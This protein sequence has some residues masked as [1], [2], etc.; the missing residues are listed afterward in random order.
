MPV[1]PVLSA[2]IPLVV[3]AWEMTAPEQPWPDPE[4]GDPD[5]PYVEPTPS[6]TGRRVQVVVHRAV[7]HEVVGELVTAE[8]ESWTED[9][10]LMVSP[11][12]AVTVS[13][14]DPLFA[15]MASRSWTGV[16]GEVVRS[17]NPKDY[18]C[19]IYLAGRPVSSWVFRRPVSTDL[20]R[21]A[22]ALEGPVAVINERFLGRIEQLDRLSGWGD[23]EN[24]PLGQE[25][26]GIRKSGP[27]VEAIVV[28]GGV[29]GTK[30]LRITGIG[31]IDTPMVAL[32][33]AEGHSR[34]TEGSLMGRWPGDIP[35]GWMVAE[36][37]TQRAD[38]T[39][40]AFPAFSR[41]N[42]GRRP[43]PL[44]DWSDQPVT[45]LATMTE[46]TIIHHTWQRIYS[47]TNPTFV[48]LVTLRQPALTG[49]LDERDLSEYP[50]RLLRTLNRTGSGGSPSGITSSIRSLTGTKA[51]MT[52]S[53]NQHP[54]A[55]EAFRAVL[56]AEGGPECRI[57]PSWVLEVWGR[58]GKSRSDLSITT[59]DVLSVTWSV[60]PG[61]QV[62]DF[63]GD[64]G[65]GSGTSLVTASVSQPYRQ[66]QHRVTK[67][68]RVPVGLTLNAAEAWVRAHARVAARVQTVVTVEVAWAFGWTIGTG[69]DLWVSVQ[70][71][72][73]GVDER[74]RVVSREFR[75][76]AGTIRL[77]LGALDA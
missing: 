7:T 23:F 17:W 1:A 70:D 53:H 20:G 8:V 47:F 64:T 48:D 30:C 65:I 72:G 3:E 77:M 34:H 9:V 68:A 57:T 12:A 32:P 26:P 36:T 35:E 49:F 69:D 29:R 63:V 5:V 13:N 56:E 28:A 2:P 59:H 33:G 60:D 54:V 21:S 22:L 44:A 45:S 37:F 46:S 24:V 39:A 31:W 19:T 75:P 55:S 67:V 66:D 74:M 16:D 15:A 41:A 10:D 71:G 51:S 6:R 11:S 58:L 4:P 18:T 61:A 25:P 62:E 42:A 76:G 38:A 27:G 73:L 43:G 50:P 14:Q 52:W 40:P